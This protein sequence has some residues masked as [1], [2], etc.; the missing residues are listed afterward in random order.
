M[1][2]INGGSSPKSWFHARAKSVC[3]LIKK[4]KHMIRKPHLL[5]KKATKLLA[6]KIGFE[7]V[8]FLFSNFSQY[9]CSFQILPVTLSLSS[10]RSP[11]EKKRAML[12]WIMSPSKLSRTFRWLS[13]MLLGT[14]CQTIFLPF[15]PTSRL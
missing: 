13:L 2:I 6:N 7:V 11:P 10:F 8:A 15:P 5:Y 14:P 1:T 9:H 3:I 4:K 12:R